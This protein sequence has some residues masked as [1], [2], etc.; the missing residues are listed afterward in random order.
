MSNLPERM[1]RV[2]TLKTR[3]FNLPKNQGVLELSVGN[4]QATHGEI[5]L[6]VRFIPHKVA[7]VPESLIDY[8][9]QMNEHFKDEL[10]TFA[11]VCLD[12]LFDTLVPQY[13]E[14]IAT[15]KLNNAEVYRCTFHKGQIGYK[16]PSEMKPLFYS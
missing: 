14:V 11:A 4:L 6:K 16:L 10:E 1:T 13:M 15:E 12:D 3:P 8:C 7:L 9:N 5:F 2:T